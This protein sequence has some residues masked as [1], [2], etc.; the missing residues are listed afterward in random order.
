MLNMHEDTY[1][2]R[3]RMYHNSHRLQY[4]QEGAALKHSSVKKI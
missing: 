3:I 2:Y 4:L 1:V